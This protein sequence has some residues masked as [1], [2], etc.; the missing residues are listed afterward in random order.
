MKTIM[1]YKDIRFYPSSPYLIDVIATRWT[2]M[3]YR[4]ISC[5]NLKNLPEADL[6]V[7]HVD[8]TVVSE[9]YTEALAKYPI[10]LNRN[11]F[12][13]SKNRISSNIL[14]RAEDYSGPVI[15]KTDANFGGIPEFQYKQIPPKD[16]VKIEVMR[17]WG[18]IAVLD[19]DNYPILSNKKHVPD[20]V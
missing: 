13:V 14:Q 6:V 11:V 4:V 16:A 19:P 20:V 8:K 3:G 18:E 5:Y 12:D 15:I 1:L 10:V 9:K 2:D 17:N 7:L